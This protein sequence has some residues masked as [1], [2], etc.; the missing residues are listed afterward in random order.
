MRFGALLVGYAGLV[1]ALEGGCGAVTPEDGMPED[2]MATRPDLLKREE[3]LSLLCSS[4]AQCS[5]GN[6]CTIDLCLAGA[7]IH[8]PDLGCC[9]RDSDCHTDAACTVVSCVLNTCIESAVLGCGVAPEPTTG[10]VTDATEAQF[11]ALCASD[12]DCVDSDPCTDNVCLVGGICLFLSNPL[13]CEE[14]S[15][16]D[17]LFTCHDGSCNDNRCELT[18]ASCDADDAGEA[19]VTVEDSG[20]IEVLCSTDNDCE[21]ADPC[22]DD[23]CLVGGACVF[24][25]NLLCCDEA[26]DCDGLLACHTGECLNNRCSLTV[27]P[28][29][30]VVDGGADT[31]GFVSQTTDGRGVDLSDGDATT[32]D[33]TTTDATTT[34]ATTTDASTTDASTVVA[35]NTSEGSWSAPALVTTEPSETSTADDSSTLVVGSDVVTAAASADTESAGAWKPR[36]VPPF[37]DVTSGDVAILTATNGELIDDHDMT[38]M[39]DQDSP[40]QPPITTNELTGGAC[41]VGAVGG[42]AHSRYWPLL[43]LVLGAFRRRR[44]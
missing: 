9:E 39:D 4:S 7:C 31:D 15:D 8:G 38:A 36:A 19:A 32:T 6:S 12:D 22:T 3:A 18:L 2:G 21:D 26:A 37:T 29:C 41:S 1:V 30:P 44:Q 20:T 24:A 33:A 5:D 23:V 42:S 16:C 25:S 27:V 14:D 10:A 43:A 28:D 13:C 35:A 17:G 11:Q 40:R 34:D